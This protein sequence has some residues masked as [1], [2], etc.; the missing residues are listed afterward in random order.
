MFGDKPEFPCEAVG[1]SVT[2]VLLLLGGV[3][4]EV[5][6]GVVVVAVGGGM[7]AEA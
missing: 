6:V 5:P 7:V 1:C 4:E 3:V 2:E